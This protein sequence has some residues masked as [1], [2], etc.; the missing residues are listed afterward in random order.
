MELVR[1]NARYH[2]AVR[3]NGSPIFVD[4]FRGFADLEARLED[5]LGILWESFRDEARAICER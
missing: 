4:R 2:C 3:A 1:H 5:R